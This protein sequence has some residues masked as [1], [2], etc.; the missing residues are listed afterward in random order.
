MLMQF[1]CNYSVMM[2]LLR[3]GKVCL[4]SC[5]VCVRECTLYFH[6]GCFYYTLGNI[7]P[8]YRSALKA[9]QIL[10][11]VEVPLLEKYGD[12][13]I[14]APAVED[15]KKLEEVRKASSANV[16]SCNIIIMLS[17]VYSTVSI[18]N[19]HGLLFLCSIIG[20]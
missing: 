13:Q 18:K 1:Q 5:T 10:C 11:L 6:L 17:E 9:I 3:V 7:R 8:K 20:C 19:H 15:L 14:L 4:Q 16:I 12:D 2:G